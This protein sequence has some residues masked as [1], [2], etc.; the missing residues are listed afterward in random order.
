MKKNETISKRFALFNIAN[1][2]YDT[3]EFEAFLKILKAAF[4]N[5]MS[6]PRS[7]TYDPV[8]NKQLDTYTMIRIIVRNFIN[9]YQRIT[10]TE[11]QLQEF[12]KFVDSYPV[13]QSI[14]ILLITHPVFRNM[15]DDLHE[16]YLKKLKI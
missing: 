7:Y 12:I 16:L 15:I 8:S 1:N 11:S 13:S 3:L 9:G 14:I 4:I 10:Y 2:E 5:I 6:I